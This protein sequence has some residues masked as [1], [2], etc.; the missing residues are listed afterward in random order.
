MLPLGDP[1]MSEWSLILFPDNLF[2]EKRISINWQK[3]PID[4]AKLKLCS[5]RILY[6]FFD[7]G[8]KS[9]EKL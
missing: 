4:G 2:S 3:Q 8:L 7:C 1:I 5:E 6:K 9:D